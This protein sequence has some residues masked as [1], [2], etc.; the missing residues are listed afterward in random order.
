MWYNFGMALYFFTIFRI[1][2]YVSVCSIWTFNLKPFIL[3]KILIRNAVG[4]VGNKYYLWHCPHWATQ[5]R[6]LRYEIEKGLRAVYIGL[7]LWL[8][9]LM[10]RNPS[11]T[12]TCSLLLRTAKC[13]RNDKC[14]FLWFSH[15]LSWN[16]SHCKICVA[17]WRRSFKTEGHLMYCFLMWEFQDTNKWNPLTALDFVW[18]FNWDYKILIEQ[19]CIALFSN[20][21]IS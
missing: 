12:S 1:I 5:V 9:T 17:R 7:Q 10:S 15:W 6:I 3:A 2:L 19:K 21:K 4:A 13:H 16:F 18:K 11:L 14:V 20:V 8:H